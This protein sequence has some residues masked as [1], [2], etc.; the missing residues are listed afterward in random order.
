M[1]PFDKPV[2]ALGVVVVV[3]VGHCPKTGRAPVITK[4]TTVK[5]IL[6]LFII[7]VH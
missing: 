5:N 4:A 3:I 7:S 1:L 6:I 2:Q